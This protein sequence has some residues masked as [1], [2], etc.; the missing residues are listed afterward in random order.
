MYP[1]KEQVSKRKTAIDLE[2]NQLIQHRVVLEH[3]IR[4]LEQERQILNQL[5][6][7]Q[8]W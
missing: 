1:N 7:L 8:P 4:R 6:D 2:L 5:E 3:K